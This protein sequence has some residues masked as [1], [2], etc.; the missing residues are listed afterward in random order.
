MFFCLLISCCLKHMINCNNCILCNSQK[1]I[2]ADYILKNL[3][4]EII[5]IYGNSLKTIN[6]L[7]TNNFFY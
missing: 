1:M 3:Q 4:R 2:S 6:G 5:N 7:V